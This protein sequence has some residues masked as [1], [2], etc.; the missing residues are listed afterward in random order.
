MDPWFVACLF[1]MNTVGVVPYEIRVFGMVMLLKPTVLLW[2][3]T[4]KDT[5]VDIPGI[6]GWFVMIV[7]LDICE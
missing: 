3:V 4:V 6:P 5:V 2:P 7:M 1:S